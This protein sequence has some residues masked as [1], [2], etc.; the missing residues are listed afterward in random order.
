M[1]TSRSIPVP[2]DSLGRGWGHWQPPPHSSKCVS[3]ARIQECGDCATPSPKE[4][5]GAMDRPQ[6]AVLLCQGALGEG[7][8]HERGACAHQGI[9]HPTRTRPGPRALNGL[10]ATPICF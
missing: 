8:A 9:A 5:W 4:P 6:G 3:S 10:L 7:A 1:V 2:G